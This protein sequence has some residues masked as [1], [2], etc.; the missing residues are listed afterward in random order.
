MV[1][2]DDATWEKRVPNP[3][4]DAVHANMHVP[5][6]AGNE[7]IGTLGVASTSPDKQ[8]SEETIALIEQFAQLASIAYINAQLHSSLVKSKEEL[9]KN[10]EE[11][12]AAHE[13]VL[14]SEEELK[15]QVHELFT[16][17]EEIRRQNI[18]LRTLHETALGLMSRRT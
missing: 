11:L 13:E 5:L 15:E 1:I 18:V 16:R 17:E 4:F 12:A 10:N 8:F 7:V 6:K 3:L 2:P 9:Q 14:A